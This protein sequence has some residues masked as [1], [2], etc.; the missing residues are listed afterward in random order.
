MPTGISSSLRAQGNTD[1][2]EKVDEPSMQLNE[3]IRLPNNL[4]KT[5]GLRSRGT[6]TSAHSSGKPAAAC[7]KATAITIM[8]SRG[9]NSWLWRG[10]A[11]PVHAAT[12]RRVLGRSLGFDLCQ[13]LDPGSEL[14]EGGRDHG[15]R[16]HGQTFSMST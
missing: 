8:A 7:Q 4:R 15:K 10:I 2:K 14:A 16:L 9:F 6:W 3:D 11:T 13:L 1:F 12:N 5:A